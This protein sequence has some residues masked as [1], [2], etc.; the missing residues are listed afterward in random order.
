MP[1]KPISSPATPP[2]IP[3]TSRFRFSWNM[4]F[5]SYRRKASKSTCLTLSSHRH[6]G[7]LGSAQEL[8]LGIDAA[9]HVGVLRRD[10]LAQ[11]DVGG[12]EAHGWTRLRLAGQAE[13]TDLDGIR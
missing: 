12:D 10:A 11:L 3:V 4:G 1:S 13:L 8:V 7:D 9:S 2:S 6:F 5:E